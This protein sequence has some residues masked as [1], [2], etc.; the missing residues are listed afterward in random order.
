MT[1]LYLDYDRSASSIGGDPGI[2]RAFGMPPIKM[3]G[4]VRNFMETLQSVYRW[5][6]VTIE[7]PVLGEAAEQ[8]ETR[9]VPNPNG[10]QLGLGGIIIDSITRLADYE[11]DATIE[12]M[13]AQREEEGKDPLDN[14]SRTWWGNYG[15]RLTRMFKMFS[16]MDAAVIATA[17]EAI[18]E[19]DVGR[20]YRT[21][22]MKGSAADRI[23][24]YFDVVSF[25]GTD[26]DGKDK[27]RY[28]RVAD[29]PKY[30]QAKD[31][32]DLLGE[33][34]PFVQNGDLRDDTLT[35]VVKTY[36]QNGTDHPNILIVGPS[37]AG[38]TLL[39]STL[40]KIVNT[41]G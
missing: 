30:R 13:N 31:R 8:T 11:L 7:H 34:V 28:M 4:G 12:R 6:E 15:D 20:R 26:G 10:D 14:L 36:R 39:V 1:F 27:D 2:K 41:D 33:K 24:E 22:N 35:Q 40:H 32:L 9:I 3:N 21:I 16:K 19:D 29:S 5:E 25:L 38:K 23:P 17:H 37:G 18:N